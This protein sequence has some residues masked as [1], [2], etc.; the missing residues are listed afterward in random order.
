MCLEFVY[1][2]DK[3]RF[4]SNGTIFKLLQIKIQF[5]ALRKPLK[6]IS[7][8]IC[9][10]FHVFKEKSPQSLYFGP[11]HMLPAEMLFPCA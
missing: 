11:N 4:P 10:V 5:S 6:E 1:V 7:G 2:L 9:L 8:V 3:G